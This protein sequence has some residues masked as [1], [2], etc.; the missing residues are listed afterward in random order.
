MR[1]GARYMLTIEARLWWH[2]SSWEKEAQ[3]SGVK[4]TLAYMKI[5]LSTR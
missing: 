3:G 5:N 1:G 4:A 2:T